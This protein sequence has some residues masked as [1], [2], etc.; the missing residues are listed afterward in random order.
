MAKSAA[1][2]YVEKRLAL[3]LYIRQLV[4][5]QKIKTNSINCLF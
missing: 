4:L 3:K 5:N 1:A 2:M